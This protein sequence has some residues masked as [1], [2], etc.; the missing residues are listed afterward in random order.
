MAS[1]N[2]R[3]SGASSVTVEKPLVLPQARSWPSG[4]QPTANWLRPEL[5]SRRIELAGVGVPEADAAQR[6]AGGGGLAVAEKGAGNYAV[7]VAVEARDLAAV[8]HAQHAGAM[9]GC[10][11]LLLQ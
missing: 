7:A 6:V 9:R 3:S 2:V 1:E 5:S 10:W 8:D 4:L 11:L